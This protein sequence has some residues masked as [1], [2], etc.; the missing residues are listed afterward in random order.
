MPTA[1][2]AVM[3]A[4]MSPLVLKSMSVYTPASSATDARARR[5]SNLAVLCALRVALNARRREAERS[6]VGL[7]GSSVSEG[8]W[9]GFGLKKRMTAEW[10]V[11]RGRVC[12]SS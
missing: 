3:T 10:G 2:H 4:N 5:R 8:S 12:R 6:D 11:R 7:S 9:I 1:P